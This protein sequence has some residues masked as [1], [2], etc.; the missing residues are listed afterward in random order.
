M[1]KYLLLALAGTILLGAT[2]FLVAKKHSTEVKINEDVQTQWKMFK[3]TFGKKFAD[4]EQEHYRI[5][6]FAENLETIKNDKTGTLGIT[7]FA[8]LSHE[9]FKSIYLTLQV[10]SSEVK[11]VEYEVAADDVSINWVTAGK[12]TAVKNQGN[13]GS[14]WSFSTTGSFESALIIA[15]KANNTLNLSEQQLI[16]CSYLNHGCNGGLMDKAFTYIKNHNLTTEAEYP[17]QAKQGKCQ[18]VTG[19]QYSLQSYTDVKQGDIQDLLN[20]LQKQPVAIAVDANNWKLYTGGVFSNCGTSLDH[21]VL[22]VGYENNAWIVKNSW[23]T[24]WGEKGYI[25]L[26]SG[27]T[28]GLA[29]NASYPNV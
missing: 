20:S 13:C 19:T 25:R 2:A 5:E 4:P 16:D 17:Y 8:D 21:G 3:K 7:Q 22:L 12:V 27:N 23:G 14:C 11:T 29:N 24:T 9:E 6:I 1:N 18:K 28:C 15:N 26:A 10:E